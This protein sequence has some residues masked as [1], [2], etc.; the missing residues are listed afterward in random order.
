MTFYSYEMSKKKKKIHNIHN[1][2]E[3]KNGIFKAYLLLCELL[4]AID[5]LHLVP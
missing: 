3:I 5:V 4:S 2:K 1:R